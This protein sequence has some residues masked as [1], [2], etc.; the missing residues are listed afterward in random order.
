ML[1]GR[2]R[3]EDLHKGVMKKN[4]ISEKKRM[5]K[6]VEGRRKGKRFSWNRFH[7]QRGHGC[8]HFEMTQVIITVNYC[9]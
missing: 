2:K 8:G 9:V 7:R 1:T 6:R 4:C 3:N 5:Q